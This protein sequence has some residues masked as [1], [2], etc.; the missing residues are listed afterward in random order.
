MT[1][2]LAKV[3]GL[4]R[5]LARNLI[6]KPSPSGPITQDFLRT[7][8]LARV[9][10]QADGLVGI[11]R[12]AHKAFTDLSE[13]IIG[14]FPAMERGTIFGNF[15]TELFDFLATTYVG[16]DPAS[17]SAVEVSALHD[18]FAA[19]FAKL[20]S[21]RRI[22]VPCVI[23]PWS[24]PR[25]SVGP[26]V[27]IFIEEAINEFYPRGDPSDILSRDGFDRMLQLMRDAHANWL[28][29]VPIQGSEHQR[30][31]E[32]G[33]LAVDLA[34][35]ALQ[36]AAP[37]L[38]TRTMSRLDARRGVAEK[39]TLSEAHGY[40]NA[41]WTKMEPGLAIGTGTLADILQKTEPL[42][43]AVGSCVKSFASGCFRF[44]N[45]ERAWCDAAYWL[46]EALAEPLDSIAVAKL[47]TAL[48]VLLNAENASGSQTRM[49]T[50]LETF[51][52]LKPED[53]LTDG[54]TT[55]AKQFARSVVRDR[56][57][58]LHGTWST[59]NSRLASNRNGLENFVTTVIRRAALELENYALTASP[60]DSIDD[61]L[62]WV[63]R[64]E[65]VRPEV[66]KRFSNIRISGQS[67][68][69]RRQQCEFASRIV[70]VM[71]IKAADVA[72]EAA[73]PE[74]LSVR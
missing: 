20:A 4:L 26:A 58:I 62:A 65:A 71:S 21:P 2:Q 23:S 46:H 24:A 33:A 47:E 32:I 74:E 13:S 22:F 55:T 25:F 59:L 48:E 72:A 11:L 43:T 44:P 29:C 54:A 9:R 17:I 42:I 57:R 6:A 5:T 18:H 41:G 8:G 70:A 30:A 67:G 69:S 14:R 28:A 19:W 61:F 40:Y 37:A 15:E 63:K 66:T 34:I 51:Y 12:P 36:L 73:G 60:E 3:V 56:S 53:P 27:F 49:L 10:R 31:E 16:R 7:E 52:G 38:D 50:I 68:N 35:V 1:T 45:L 64:R 39:R